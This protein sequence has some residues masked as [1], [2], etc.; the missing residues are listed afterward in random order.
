MLNRRKLVM[1][2]MNNEGIHSLM[3]ILVYSSNIDYWLQLALT[4]KIHMV[5]SSMPTRFCSFNTNTQSIWWKCY[6]PW[7]NSQTHFSNK[8]ECTVRL[9]ISFYKTIV[10]L[11]SFHAVF[12]LLVQ[13]QVYLFNC[14]Q[15]FRITWSSKSWTV[16]TTSRS[17]VPFSLFLVLLH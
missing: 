11:H 14:S 12:H 5:S 10:L 6:W 16:M 13:Y 15:S 3:L 9:L 7:H 4:I 17:H 2:M 8:Q 1:M